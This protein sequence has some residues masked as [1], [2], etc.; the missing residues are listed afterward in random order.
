MAAPNVFATTTIISNSGVQ[1]VTNSATAIITNASSSG[2]VYMVKSLYVT[3][4]STT[5][6]GTITVDLFRSSVAYR[7][8]PALSVPIQCTIVPIEAEAP[9]FMLEG[10][11]LRLTASANSIFEAVASWDEVNA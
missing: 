2:K 1:A 5:V 3:N 10:D 7:I 4:V 6:S 8:V 9:I 11:T